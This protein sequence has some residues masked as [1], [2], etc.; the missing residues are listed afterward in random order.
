MKIRH[1]F[2]VLLVFVFLLL[3]QSCA[4]YSL[5]PIYT[6]TDVLHNAGLLGTWQAIDEKKLYAIFEE[7]ESGGYRTTY[8]D[9]GDTLRFLSHL[10]SIGQYTFLDIYPYE[11]CSLPDMD[12]CTMTDNLMKNYIPVHTFMRFD[13]EDGRITLIDFDN[14]K[15]KEL[16]LKNKIRL[17]HEVIGENSIIVITAS[18]T[19]LRKFIGKYAR[20]EKV[21]S[22]TTHFVKISSLPAIK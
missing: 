19:D 10:T 20:E 12:D 4:I 6:E 5:H 1:L 9:D 17:D 8:V 15:L 3:L 22:D 18:T 21:F 11:D 14:D 7:V 13:F 16:F 2:L